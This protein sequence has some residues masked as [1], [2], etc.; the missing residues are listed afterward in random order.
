M[1]NASII[2]G[3]TTVKVTQA[4]HAQEALRWT[5]L[6]H[7]RSWRSILLLTVEVTV[8]ERMATLGTQQ[9]GGERVC[10]LRSK[11]RKEIVT[12]HRAV[13]QEPSGLDC[14]APAH[15]SIN[16]LHPRNACVQAPEKDDWAH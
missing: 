5:Q 10:G 2:D 1:N 11:S 13:C 7:D 16:P 12:S 3:R 9:A 4:S 14:P 8:P 6:G 15:S